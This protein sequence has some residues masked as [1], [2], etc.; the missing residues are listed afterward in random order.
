MKK[1][2]KSKSISRVILVAAAVSFLLEQ[3]APA[4]ATAVDR[5]KT[6]NQEIQKK[7]EKA[8]SRPRLFFRAVTCASLF[9]ATAHIAGVAVQSVAD[10]VPFMTELMNPEKYLKP[11][12]AGAID[13]PMAAVGFYAPI[14][15][16]LVYTRKR[17]VLR[18]NQEVIQALELAYSG[19]MNDPH[20]D[21]FCQSI[22][23]AVERW[24]QVKLSKLETIALM[25]KWNEEDPDANARTI[26]YYSMLN[27]AVDSTA[28]K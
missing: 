7:L 2:F 25:Q 15:Y 4:H 24:K 21:S 28:P 22:A 27:Y 20:L 23:Q 3:S 5:L 18:L 11:T 8:P 1:D 17:N 9:L 19:K 10:S 13:G 6:E 16:N 12:L 14:V 26:S